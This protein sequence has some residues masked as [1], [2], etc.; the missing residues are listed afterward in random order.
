M[1]PEK[2][3]VDLELPRL[4]AGIAASCRT[5]MGRRRALGWDVPAEHDETMARLARGR[6]ALDLT[7]R[8]EPL[9]ISSTNDLG[10]SLGRLSAF[11]VLAGPELLAVTEVLAQARAV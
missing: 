10:D 6:E 8:G 3:R 11:G 9:P 2:A 7:N 5:P 1:L 4:W